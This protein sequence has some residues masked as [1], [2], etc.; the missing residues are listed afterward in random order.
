MQTT[1]FAR[2]LRQRQTEAEAALWRLLRNRGAGAKF[3]RQVPIAG[4]VADFLSNEPKLI[5]E[6]D[7]SQHADERFEHDRERTKR[8]EAAGFTV[9]RFWN[10]GVLRDPKMARDGIGSMIEHLRRRPSP[11][12]NRFRPLPK[13]EVGNG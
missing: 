12:I 3:R 5:V 1:E 8:L 2:G 11:E 6:L 10:G 7:G 13:G 9:M 4:Y